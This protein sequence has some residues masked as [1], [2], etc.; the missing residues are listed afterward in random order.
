MRLFGEIT[1]FF[2][3]GRTDEELLKV[4]QEQR[5]V[6]LQMVGYFPGLFDRRVERASLLQRKTLY[7]KS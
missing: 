7:V 5:V 1:W 6:H 2:D 4:F 3:G